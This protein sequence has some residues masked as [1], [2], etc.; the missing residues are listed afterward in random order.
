MDKRRSTSCS[1]ATESVA[2]GDTGAAFH[3][4]RSQGVFQ[5]KPPTGAKRK[6]AKPPRAK[7]GDYHGAEVG[8]AV[9]RETEAAEGGAPEGLLESRH[10]TEAPVRRHGDGGREGRTMNRQRRSQRPEERRT[11]PDARQARSPRTAG[12]EPAENQPAGS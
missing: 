5:S 2:V 1:T 12:S 6:E 9:N 4:A 11:E 10:E 8:A 3:A 7:P